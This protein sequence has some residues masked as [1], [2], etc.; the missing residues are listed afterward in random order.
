MSKKI[1]IENFRVFKDYTEFEIRPITLLTGPNNS[2]KSSFT[3]LLLLLQN[4]LEKL[5]FETGNHNLENF[6][7]VLN[8]KNDKKEIRITLEN[9]IPVLRKD[10]L[11]EIIYTDGKISNINIGK[12]DEYMLKFS[13]KETVQEGEYFNNRSENQSFNLNINLLIQEILSYNICVRHNV[14]IPS[15]GNWKSTWTSLKNVDRTRDKTHSLKL[16]G[17]EEK[18]DEYVKKGHYSDLDLLR[19]ITLYNEIDGLEN[20]GLLYYV[21]VGDKD[22]SKFYKKE[23]LDLQEKIFS[24]ESEFGSGPDFSSDEPFKLLSHLIKIIPNKAKKD[25][26]EFFVQELKSADVNC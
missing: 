3:K 22:V 13:L 25:L 14:I 21:K 24:M 5:N 7:K 8:W 4:G 1:G 18:Y 16:S 11:T 10:L 2:G 19:N 26:K 9:N 6:E 23:I 17:L 20:L 15:S 12:Q